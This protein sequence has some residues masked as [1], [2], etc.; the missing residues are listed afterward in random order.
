MHT[1]SG[2]ISTDTDY[3][4]EI[5]LHSNS[6]TG[7]ITKISD[8]TVVYNETITPPKDFTNWH[9]CMFLFHGGYSSTT[10]TYKEVKIKPL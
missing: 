8:N 5:E 1:S 7:K 9:F 4:F 6:M 3:L 10:V 2:A